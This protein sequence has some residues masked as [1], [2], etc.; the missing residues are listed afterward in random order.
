MKKTFLI[1]AVMT[2]ILLASCGYKEYGDYKYTDFNQLGDW[3]EVNTIGQ[4]GHEL[5]YVYDRDSLGTSC[6]GCTVVNEPLFTYGQENEDGITLNVAN[7][8]TVQGT[9]PFEISNRTPRVYVFYETDIVDRLDDASAIL[10][11]LDSVES[12]EYD[13]PEE[14]QIEE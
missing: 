7:I 8:K 11:F 4:D 3:E 5:L 10:D 14:R 6:A 2:T 9:K 12:G 1:L 13:W